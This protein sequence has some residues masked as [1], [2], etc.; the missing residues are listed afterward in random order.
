MLVYQN[1]EYTKTCNNRKL[2]NSS[3][4]RVDAPFKKKERK[5]GYKMRCY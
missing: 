4:Q 5:K 2:Y 1:F 3:N